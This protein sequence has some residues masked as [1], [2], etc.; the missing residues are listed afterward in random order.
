MIPLIHRRNCL[1]LLRRHPHFAAVKST[2]YK[3]YKDGIWKTHLK[4][5][6]SSRHKQRLMESAYR[7]VTWISNGKSSNILASILHVTISSPNASKQVSNKPFI[8]ARRAHTAASSRRSQ[9]LLLLQSWPHRWMDARRACAA[10]PAGLPH[11]P[12][13]GIKRYPVANVTKR[14]MA[15]GFMASMDQCWVWCCHKSLAWRYDRS[16]CILSLGRRSA[17]AASPQCGSDARFHVVQLRI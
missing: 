9:L 15:A 12:A 11:S 1:P 3:R 16:P 14:A 6:D 10:S 13:V 8:S 17:R 7:N 2:V 5:D 4:C